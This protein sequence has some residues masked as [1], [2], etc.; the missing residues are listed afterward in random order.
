MAKHR[1]RV[2]LHARNTADFAEH[3]YE[4]IR[5]ARIE[6]LKM[7]SFTQTGVYDRLRQE[8]PDIEFI[9]RLYDDRIRRD[10]RASPA[11]FVSKMLPIIRCLKPYTTKFEI[12]NEPNHVSG[13]E[14]WGASDDNARSFREWYIQVLSA[15]K[16]ACPWAEFGFPGLA[17]NQPHRDLAWLDICRVAIEASDWLGCHCYWQY[18]NMLNV[19]WG[20]RL[21]L[22][23]ERFPDMP[24]EVTEFGNSTP[25][26]P[27]EEMGRQYVQY[28]QALNE[29]PYLRSASSFLASSPDAAW[30]SFAWMQESGT[31]LPVVHSVGNMERK[32]AEIS[33]PEK[34]SL[35][36][37]PKP[38]LSP[39]QKRAFSQ[40]GKT[41]RGK[42]LEFFDEYGLDICGYPI[43]EQFKESGLQSQYF[44]RVAL[45]E[46]RSGQIRLKPV[47]TEVWSSRPRIAKLEADLQRLGQKLL[48][49]GPARP[50]VQDITDRLPTH[51]TRRYPSRSLAEID[52]LVIHHTATDPNM[53]PQRLAEY[54]VQKLGRAR[55]VYHFCI[56]SDGTIYQTNRLGTVSNHAYDKNQTSLGICFIGDFTEAVPSDAQLEAGGRLCAWLIGSLR[57]PSSAIVGLSELAQTQ[58]P[59]KQWL[60][61]QRWK[62]RLMEEVES[63]LESSVEGKQ[64]LVASLRAQIR[65]LEDEIRELEEQL[66]M[67]SF[68]FGA[69]PVEPKVSQPPIR[70]L[71]HELPK[72]STKEYKTRPLGNIRCLVIHHSAVPPSVGPRRI[73]EYHVTKQD[74]PGIGYHFLI[75]EN[76]TIFQ[77]NALETISYHA[78]QANP[79]GVGISF[80]GNFTQ[81]VPPPA[82]L[83]AGAHL[84]AWLM[85]RLGIALVDVKGHKEFMDTACPGRQWLS[86]KKW[87]QMLR[88]EIMRIQEEAAHPVPAP[89]PEGKT[90]HHY[91]LFWGREAEWANRDWLNAQNYVGTFRSTTGF[92]IEEAS[93]A[94]NVTIVGGPLGVSKDVEDRLIA[95]GCR[96]DRIAG[97]DEADTKRLL[98][99]LAER[100]TRFQNFEE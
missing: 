74:W 100:G 8:H 13:I 2:G 52:T 59:G 55:I 78:V 32:P 89:S 5:R 84:I 88:Q 29:Y 50:P 31:M 51:A 47:G 94:E 16:K 4:L 46:L 1:T 66:A 11:Q 39:A 56:A 98:D 73:A 27:R 49:V 97:K 23:H 63:A 70:N 57:L 21:T 44:Q 15:L 22:Y 90:L 3:D 95:A 61:D 85:E 99:G 92:S 93:Q 96:V 64:A 60:S 72:H 7:M 28:Y 17:L 37:K 79:R 33:P 19:R 80:L 20:L 65:T 30:A 6:T 77:G 34:P 12:H 91:M 43:T 36:P 86:G 10:S 41:V 42:F 82:Q 67:P 81:D 48:A 87:K 62:D 53:T 35:P 14:G 25:G 26:L 40:T 69:E 18:G 58:S 24:I 75:G 54:Q 38:E 76:G 71:I 83:R 9:V 68:S 45:E